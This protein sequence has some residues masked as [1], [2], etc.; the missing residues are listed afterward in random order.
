M[1]LVFFLDQIQSGTGSK[2]VKDIKLGFEKGTIGASSTLEQYVINANFKPLATLFCGTSYYFNNKEEVKS[3]IIGFLD[4]VMTDV[5]LFGP[6]YNYEEYIKISLELAVFVLKQSK[7]I[8]IVMCNDENL[9]FIN[10]YKDKVCILKMPKKG[11][12]GLRE[13]FKKLENTLKCI[14]EGKNVCGLL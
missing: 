6:C 2:D 4:K 14:K 11:G 5:I 13:S 10:E 8:P 9:E 3:K 7:T 1:R 12:T